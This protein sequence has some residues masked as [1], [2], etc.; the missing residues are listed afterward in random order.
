MHAS[1][2]GAGVR[3]CSPTGTQCALFTPTRAHSPALNHAPG[4]HAHVAPCTPSIQ[5]HADPPKLLS[6]RRSSSLLPRSG[7]RAA[8]AASPRWRPWLGPVSEGG[9]VLCPPTLRAPGRPPVSPHP[10]AGPGPMHVASPDLRV[11]AELP[12]S[13]V[14]GT[15]GPAVQDAGGLASQ[16]IACAASASPP[17]PARP[18]DMRSVAP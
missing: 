10:A 2:L 1:T 12:P 18:Q 14:R 17:S 7:P 6:P 15:C 11:G 9:D 13:S 4:G 3:F 5:T 16:P 8:C